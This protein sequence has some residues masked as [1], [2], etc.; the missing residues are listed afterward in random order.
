[1]YKSVN[2]HLTKE[3]I[4]MANKLFIKKCS[5]SSVTG[6]VTIKITVSYHLAV[7]QL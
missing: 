7:V 6:E 3:D 1:M 2:R 5:I 4:Q